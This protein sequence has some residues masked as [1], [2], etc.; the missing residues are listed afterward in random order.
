MWLLAAF[1]ASNL[2]SLKVSGATSSG[3]KS[4]LIPTPYVVK[5]A[6]IDASFRLDGRGEEDFAWIRPL[7]IA[8]QV[9]EAVVVN[10][11]FVKVLKEARDGDETYQQTVGLRQYVYWHGPIRIAFEIGGLSELQRERLS[12]LVTLVNYFGKRGSFVQY[13]GQEIT[14]ELEAGFSFDMNEPRKP[15][16]GPLSRE[17]LIQMMD[18]MGGSSGFDAF[19]SYSSSR[20]KL[21]EDRIFR[22][23]VLV[24]VK[25]ASSRGYTLYR[26]LSPSPA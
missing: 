6:L 15:G 5:M 11:N 2:F 1:S 4:H 26:A 14:A 22:P 20:Q 12:R 19:N 16:N 21:H 3:G 24:S 9:P 25:E 10:N 17:M 18:D 13:R 23:I 7:T 8:F